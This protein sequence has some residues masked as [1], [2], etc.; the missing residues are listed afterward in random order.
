MNI[1]MELGV[2]LEKMFMIKTPKKI[3]IEFLNNKIIKNLL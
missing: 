3:D 1:V 2:S